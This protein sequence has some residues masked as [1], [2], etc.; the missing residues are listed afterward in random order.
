MFLGYYAVI[1]F[2]SAIANFLR[3]L[4]MLAFGIRASRVL[5]HNLLLVVLRAPMSFFDITPVGRIVNRFSKDV[6][7]IDEQLTT[8]LRTYLQTFF[9]VISTVAVISAITPIFTLCFIP[10]II[11][12]AMQQAYFTVTTRAVDALNLLSH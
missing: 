2:S 12:Y 7:T 4:F 6:Y 8:T 9:N 5:Y 1:N 3:S 11:F 10:I